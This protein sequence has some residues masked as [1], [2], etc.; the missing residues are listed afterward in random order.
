MQQLSLCFLQEV[1]ELSKV[2]S[3]KEQT[4]GQRQATVVDLQGRL[5]QSQAV[6]DA[7]AGS[8]S[9]SEAQATSLK[10]QYDIAR[11]ASSL[12]LALSE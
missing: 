8:T 6:L 4:C 12:E 5:E 7:C 11:Q 2:A 10:E 3:N 1:H 9:C